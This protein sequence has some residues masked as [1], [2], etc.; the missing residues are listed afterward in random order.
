M[1]DWIGYLDSLPEHSLDCVVGDA[2]IA[3]LSGG[4]EA[5]RLIMS[6][7]RVL[8]SSG[9]PVMRALVML[10]LVPPSWRELRDAYRSSQLDEA[11]FGLG[12]RLL[13]FCS[14]SYLAST[15]ILDNNIVFNECSGLYQ[16]GD[17]GNDEFMIVGRY[18]LA[19]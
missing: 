10:S 11:A 16:A 17:L 19:G 12:T 4:D 5:R 9:V 3:N 14:E 18:F 8:G 15:G 13:G 6:I 7:H 2:I 1:A